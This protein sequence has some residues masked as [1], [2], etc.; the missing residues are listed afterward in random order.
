MRLTD[1]ITSPRLLI[2]KGILMLFCGLFAAALLLLLY[3]GWIT[4]GLLT[5]TI[6][7]FCRAYYF[8]FY[9]IEKYIDDRYKFAGLW[10]AV[11]FLMRR[12]ENEN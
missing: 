5:A 10:S 1:D 6:F 4:A 9:V 7:G 12:S 11:R 2:L 8:A 3:P